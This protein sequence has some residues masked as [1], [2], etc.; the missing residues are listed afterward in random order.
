MTGPRARLISLALLVVGGLGGLIATAQPWWRLVGT[1]ADAP[2]NATITGTTASAG[3]TQV[4]PACVLVSALLTLVLRSALGRRIVAVIA[5]LLGAGTAVLGAWHPRPDA[6]TIQQVVRQSSLADAATVSATAGPWVYLVTGVVVLAGAVMVV[7]YAP[8]WPRRADRYA[9]GTAAAEDAVARAAADPDTWW[10]AMDAGVDPTSA[11]PPADPP[12]ESAGTTDP[13][14]DRA[15]PSATMAGHHEQHDD[16]H[17][18]HHDDQN[19][20]HTGSGSDR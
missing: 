16:Q 20:R 4:L 10:K 15:T 5:A 3:L 7:G 18:D 8:R 13:I 1:S 6:A 9:V 12:A 2:V 17:D 11:D 14:S 19:D